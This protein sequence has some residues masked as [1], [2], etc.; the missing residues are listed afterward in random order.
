M[1]RNELIVALI[2]AD[3]YRGQWDLADVLYAPVSPAFV[4]LAHGAWLDSLPPELLDVR[5]IGGGK[6]VRCVKWVPEVYD[7]DNHT[8]SFGRFLSD[9]MAVDCI[10]TG[11]NRGNV[12]AGNFGFA[13]TPAPN[14]GHSDN[15]FVDYAGKAHNFDPGD[16]SMDKLT[17]L[18]I[19]TVF[20]GEST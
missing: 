10:K 9:C 2:T 4:Q 1:T 20:Q 19:Q 5:D 7:C 11:N 12:A 6:T 18:Q 15:W 16:E 14:D 13:R 17:A 3:M 8:R